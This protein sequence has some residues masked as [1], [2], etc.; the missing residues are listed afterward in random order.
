MVTNIVDRISQA[1]FSSLK[2]LRLIQMDNVRKIWQSQLCLDSFSRLERLHVH[3]CHKISSIFPSGMLG[4]LQHL[5]VLQVIEC[6]SVEEVFELEALGGNKTH[7][8]A[9]SQLE[10]LL[11]KKLP[12]LKHVWNMNSRVILSFRNLHELTVEYCDSLKSLL[13]AIIAKGLENLE[14]LFVQKCMM[15]KIIAM[16]DEVEGISEFVF[17]QLK[18]L[19][20]LY[21]S[22][23]KSFCSGLYISKWPM[24]KELTVWGCWE[25]EILVLELQSYVKHQH[26]SSHGRP[27]F[28]VDKVQVQNLFDICSIY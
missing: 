25:V 16:E 19:A 12:N 10:I 21:V 22:G 17:P 13:P 18:S 3:R 1:K 26:D 5:H 23:L 27:L 2:E 15:E 20:L 24:L 28:L 14:K 9:A 8:I 6:D 11:L 4:R 7:E